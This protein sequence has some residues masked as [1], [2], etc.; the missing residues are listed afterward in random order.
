MEVAMC[1]GGRLLADFEAGTWDQPDVPEK[2][3]RCLTSTVDD[4]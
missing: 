3:A 4:R 2:V 1:S